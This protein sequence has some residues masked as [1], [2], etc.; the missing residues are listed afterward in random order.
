MILT[1][2]TMTK[3][4]DKVP[5]WECASDDKKG[6]NFACFIRTPA[7]PKRI[8][9]LGPNTDPPYSASEITEI[10][11]GVYISKMELPYTEFCVAGDDLRPFIERYDKAA[12]HKN[13]VVIQIDRTA[14]TYLD[15]GVSPSIKDSSASDTTIVNTF[16]AKDWMGCIAVIGDDFERGKYDPPRI[17]GMYI[18]YAIHDMPRASMLHELHIKG[19][20]KGVSITDSTVDDTEV[21][22][23]LLAV[24]RSGRAKQ[25][26]RI[27][28]L[29]RLSNYIII[30]EGTTDAAE[31][32]KNSSPADYL[33]NPF[34]VQFI[35]VP[36]DNECNVVETDYVKEEVL[37]L[38][39]KSRTN[40]NRSVIFYDCRPSKTF[41]TVNL[42]YIFVASKPTKKK[43]VSYVSLVCP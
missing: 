13:V 17:T 33:D 43:P 37:P 14:Y 18:D 36:V 27:R 24:Y 9:L 31:L 26:F 5:R 20:P 28:T 35:T 38:F 25:S 3:D 15:S 12:P 1:F 7:F 42:N 21:A 39:E 29:Q 23:K 30:P 6:N 16:H 32:F 34:D 11:P 19:N 8:M 4:I 41:F 10:Q 22:K 40:K 2:I